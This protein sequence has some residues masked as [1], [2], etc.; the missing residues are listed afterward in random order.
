MLY[1]D[2]VYIRAGLHLGTPV[3]HMGRTDEAEFLRER[4][5]FQ[6]QIT[7]KLRVYGVGTLRNR[8]Q[9]LESGK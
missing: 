3:V 7:Q 2:N 9:H 4:V 8:V 1:L 5:R 6:R